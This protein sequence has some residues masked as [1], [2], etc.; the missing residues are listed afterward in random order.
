[1]AL[2]N[3]NIVSFGI[4]THAKY[5]TGMPLRFVGMPYPFTGLSE[6]KL[7]TY[8]EEGRDSVTDK[9]ILLNLA[10][11]ELKNLVTGWGEPGY[12]SEQIETWLYQCYVD[13]AAQMTNLP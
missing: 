8:L 9:P 2:S 7:K 4:D 12:R 10:P 6:Q 1:M 11:T 5:S 3:E 13:D